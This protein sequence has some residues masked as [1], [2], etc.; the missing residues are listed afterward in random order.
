MSTRAL[1]RIIDDEE[2]PL[3]NI[4]RSID[5]HPDT[6]GKDIFNFLDGLEIVEGFSLGQRNHVA[7]GASDLAALLVKELKVGPGGLYIYPPTKDDLGQEFEYI[8]EVYGRN[9]IGIQVFDANQRPIF[10]GNVEEFGEYCKTY[11]V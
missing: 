8:I 7:N 2:K 3:V 11:K 1:V 4:Y 10:G 9:R 6:F 5:G